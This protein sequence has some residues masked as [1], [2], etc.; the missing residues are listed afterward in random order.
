M[1]CNVYLTDQN[2]RRVSQHHSEAVHAIVQ[3]IGGQ[4]LVEFAWS[5]DM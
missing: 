2:P 3:T 4:D 1:F 5:L